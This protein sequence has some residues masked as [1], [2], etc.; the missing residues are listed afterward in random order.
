MVKSSAAYAL[1]LLLLA[2]LSAPAHAGARTS[3]KTTYYSISGTTGMDLFRDMNR[4]GPRHAFMKKAMAQTQ[5]RTMPRGKMIWKNGMCSVQDGG[6]SLDLTYVYPKP[7]S[8]LSGRLAA[9]WKAF[10]ADTYRHEK[11]HGRLAMEMAN[12]LDSTLRRFR[13]KDSRTCGH[14]LSRLSGQINAIYA[15]YKKRQVAFD[16]AEHRKGGKVEKS[17]LLLVKE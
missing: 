17:V 7:A 15:E 16:V 12:K 11:V 8:R 9:N 1:S 4:K 2:G 13:M 10:M 6:Y 5:Y 14:A 3:V